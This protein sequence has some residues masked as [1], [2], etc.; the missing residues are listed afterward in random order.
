M[1]N[2]NQLKAGTVAPE[3]LM[4]DKFQTQPDDFKFDFRNWAIN[5]D[6]GHDIEV[7]NSKITIKKFKPNVW[8]MHSEVVTGSQNHAICAYCQ[9]TYMTGKNISAYS[10]LF[11]SEQPLDNNHG[12][13]NDKPKFR[14]FC[15]YPLSTDF[16]WMQ[17]R[18]YT[19]ESCWDTADTRNS[20][21]VANW[22]SFR[23][24][25]GGYGTY[26]IW[27]DFTNKLMFPNELYDFNT[28]GRNPDNNVSWYYGFMLATAIIQNFDDGSW[29]TSNN[30]IRNGKIITIT[31]RL[32][33]NST[34]YHAI[35]WNTLKTC[36][37][38]VIGLQSGDRL[39]YGVGNAAITSSDNSITSDGTYELSTF[40]NG[41]AGAA[42]KLY[43]NTETTSE[44]TI[45]LVNDT[46]PDGIIDISDSPII[47]EIQPDNGID[48]TSIECW[49]AYVANEKIYH[50]DKT[51]DNCWK[52]YGLAFPTNWNITKTNF[53]TN[54]YVEW[55]SPT[56]FK[57]N[58]IPENGITIATTTITTTANYVQLNWKQ[59]VAKL[60]QGL[61]SG[62]TVKIVRTFTNA[63]Y[64][65]DKDTHTWSNPV[66]DIETTLSVGDN[67]IAAFS[68][69]IHKKDTDESMSYSECKIVITSNT[70]VFDILCMVEILPTFT[71]GEVL[72]VT[73]GKWG[74][75]KVN[76]PVIT[77]LDNYIDKLM[78][79]VSPANADFWTPIKEYYA[80]NVLSGDGVYKKF[81]EAKN[82]D[83]L[84]IILPNSSWLYYDYT[85][86]HASITKLT[87]TGQENTRITSLNGIFEDL[88][89]LKELI[90]NVDEAAENYLAGAN[91]C[92]NM[93]NGC[94]LETYPS[95]F[96]RWDVFRSNP[97]SY[98]KLATNTVS[99]F[100]GSN[101]K[102]IPNY[103]SNPNADANTILCGEASGIFYSCSNLETVG[104]ILDLQ[105]IKPQNSGN[106]F[107]G[108]TKLTTIRIKNLN[109]GDWHFDNTEFA[110]GKKHGTLEAL[111]VSSIQYL[112]A[113]LTDLNLYDSE[114]NIE[115]ISNSFSKWDS[116]YFRSGVFESAYNFKFN[117]MFQFVAKL[118]T[119][120]QDNAPFIVHTTATGISMNINI[121][122]LVEGDS[123]IFGAAGSTEAD[124]T[125]TSNG[126]YTITKNDTID[127]GFKLIGNS[128][129]ET[130]VTVT[131]DK[132]WDL[133]IPTVQSANLYCPAEWETNIT[134]E[135][136]T[137]ANAK[138]WTIYIGGTEKIV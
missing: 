109:H 82:L 68:D 67:T 103:G 129:N 137:A 31:T 73:A 134:D 99:M 116:D 55:V 95:N 75:N 59:F 2:I 39:E 26:G 22:S 44:V 36:K 1:A 108:C 35:R 19:W 74:L 119:A 57:I 120:T 43:G 127:K 64:D 70:P 105:L 47:I 123:L 83:E 121:S 96:I 8:I 38:K 124:F 7:T 52:K 20:P 84:S 3:S 101:I 104:P 25:S 15:P 62:V 21:T 30:A 5:K 37:V 113:N 9:G 27:S 133:S 90:V 13:G 138:N 110:S 40:G 128:S 50:K 107:I 46:Y 16:H 72:T 88:G 41:S 91:D 115:T 54:K 130:D 106:I 49:D 80:A 28:F 89:E 77:D 97:Q 69:E 114:K 125:I 87:L 24:G 86:K 14:G 98:S 135:M 42:F 51:L 85:F 61:P 71:D 65:Y 32:T 76:V 66:E 126:D 93:F 112:F 10:D 33:D 4:F 102:N 12:A 100:W 132:G 6:A 131:V 45:E 122:G 17:E 111:D 48:V 53:N 118:R 94:N 56:R 29:S 60:S 136:V 23:L 11:S 92:S 34:G 78:F 58:G 79:N 117:S 63:Y 18:M 81:Y